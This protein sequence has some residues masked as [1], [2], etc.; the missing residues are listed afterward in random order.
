MCLLSMFV[1][2]MGLVGNTNLGGRGR[3]GGWDK[4]KL[5]VV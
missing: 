3:W 4:T 1:V 2:G 5:Q